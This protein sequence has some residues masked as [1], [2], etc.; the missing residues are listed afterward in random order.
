MMIERSESLS[1]PVAATRVTYGNSLAPGL[2]GLIVFV[3]LALSDVSHAVHPGA[4]VCAVDNCKRQFSDQE[5]E[6]FEACRDGAAHAAD[7]EPSSAACLAM[8]KNRHSGG[9]AARQEACETGCALFP[10]RCL[11]FGK[12]PPRDNFARDAFRP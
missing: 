3:L 5:T 6:V 11:R 10:S 4:Y 12:L 1:G 7:S 2:I 9:N 8:C